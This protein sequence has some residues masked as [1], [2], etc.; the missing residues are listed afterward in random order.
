[1][2]FNSLYGRSR[3]KPNKTVYWRLV[4]QVARMDME[5]AYWTEEESD[6]KWLIGRRRDREDKE[7]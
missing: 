7:K 1:M 5:T 4:G 6:G 2:D 3:R